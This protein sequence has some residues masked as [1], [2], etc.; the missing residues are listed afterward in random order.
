MNRSLDAALATFPTAT[1]IDEFLSV[2]ETRVESRGF[3]ADR[4][5]AMV[6]TCRDELTHPLTRAVIDRIG[7]AFNLGALG[8]VPSLGRTGWRAALS[9][10][11]STNGRGHIVV[12]G[13]THIGFGPDGTAGESLRWHQ[14]H[15]TPTCGALMSILQA[16]D[17]ASDDTRDD[18]VLDDAEKDRL[19]QLINSVSGERSTTPV[20]ITQRAA[21]AVATEMW[22]ELE[23]LEAYRTMDVAVFCGVQIHVHDHADLIAVTDAQFQGADRVRT[24][25]TDP[26]G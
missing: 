12:I 25:L 16:E 6:S 8:G 20:N 1:T 2:V 13:M 26:T 22:A 24:P 11:P 9:H 4:T 10:V 15:V 7:L 19:R 23:A 14:D 5:L 17:D 3:S 18:T 21:E